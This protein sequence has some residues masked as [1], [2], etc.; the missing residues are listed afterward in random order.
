MR[1]VC[2]SASLGYEWEV[3]RWVDSDVGELSHGVLQ[4]CS[5]VE[6]SLWRDWVET[7]RSG[8][9]LY[10]AVKRRLL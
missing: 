6:S 5:G 9:A 10:I 4:V 1:D 3:L 2:G 8:S 7:T